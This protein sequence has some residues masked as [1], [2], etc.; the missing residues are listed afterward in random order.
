LKTV[1]IA[2]IGTRPEIIPLMLW[3]LSQLNYIIDEILLLHTHSEPLN[4]AVQQLTYWFT[5]EAH[6]K[7]YQKRY[8]IEP[9]LGQHGPIIDIRSQHEAE[10]AFEALFKKVQY[11]KLQNYEIHLFVSGGRKLLAAYG[12][13][14]AQMLFSE[15]DRLWYSTPNE[16]LF[17]NRHIIPQAGDEFYL[18]NIPI[19]SA[20]D[21][22]SLQHKLTQTDSAL[23]ALRTE[24]QL[25]QQERYRQVGVFLDDVLTKALREIVLLMIEGLSNKE[26]AKKRSVQQ[27]TVDKQI[28]KIYR[29]WEDFWELET[30]PHLRTQIITE[31]A[32]YISWREGRL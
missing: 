17:E 2:T 7:L 19:I 11:Y 22:P 12:M 1:L 14:V 18:I 10:Q 15:A 6:L 13:I 24:K 32:R 31:V 9:L 21:T 23:S 25:R 30:A 8:R 4:E 5:S 29:K 28:H 20:L 3:K 26:I 16:Q 27:N